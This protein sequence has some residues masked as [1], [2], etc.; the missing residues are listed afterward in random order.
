MPS[1]CGHIVSIIPG[2][3]RMNKIQLHRFVLCGAIVGGGWAL[4]SALPHAEELQWWKIALLIMMMLAFG[5]L[6]GWGDAARAAAVTG[7]TFVE[8]LEAN[9]SQLERDERSQAPGDQTYPGAKESPKRN[10]Q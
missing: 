10:L 8:A 7:A 1:H 2:C 5:S 6:A 9:M 4:V 3:M